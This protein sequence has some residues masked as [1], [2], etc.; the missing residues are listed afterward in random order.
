MSVAASRSS[1]AAL[2]FAAAFPAAAGPLTPP[3][4][5]VAPTYRTLAEI[6]PRKPISQPAQPASPEAVVIIDAPGSYYLTGNIVANGRTGIHIAANN[7]T[8]D[9]NGFA[10]LGVN[11]AEF[12]GI[13][14]DDS[15]LHNIRVFN[16]TISNFAAGVA[17]A[18]DN[19]VIE[20]LRIG[21]CAMGISTSSSY[22]GVCRRNTMFGL[23]DAAISMGE[24]ALIA[25][26]QIRYELGATSP[27][28]AI[29]T[30]SGSRIVGNTVHTAPGVG[31]D[32][33]DGSH[34]DS[35]VILRPGAA[36]IF[37]GAHARVTGNTIRH[38]GRRDNTSAGI[39]AVSPVGATIDGNT[40][41]DSPSAIRTAGGTIIVRNHIFDTHP[42]I[43]SGREDFIGPLVG[44]GTVLM[45]T[46][47]L[48]NVVN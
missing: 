33:G 13:S 7:V 1:I 27:D 46:S 25:D 12:P 44:P 6:E 43:E 30:G 37:A 39:R 4:G 15:Y 21:N 28:A 40:I 24:A 31:I 18:A 5:P 20:D 47:G 14:G 29:T 45:E 35:N 10:V 22:A 2:L 17:L 42:Y 9:L 19:P 32:G 38:A 36:G 48:A 41:A 26:N 16:G 34:I 11:A 3:A 23:T 8:L